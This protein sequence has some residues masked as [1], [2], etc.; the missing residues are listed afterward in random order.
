MLLPDFL[1]ADW[2]WAL[3]PVSC[4]ACPTEQ[5]PPSAPGGHAVAS[6]SG[7][8][9]HDGP[10]FTCPRLILIMATQAPCWNTRSLFCFVFYTAP[11]GP[12]SLGFLCRFFCLALN[13]LQVLFLRGPLFVPRYLP[14]VTSSIPRA[15]TTTNK[16]MTLKSHL[17][18]PLSWVTHTAVPSAHLPPDVQGTSNTTWK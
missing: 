13:S 4:P 11:F 14:R 9:T 7:H 15:S 2:Q 18:W 16:G 6:P 5:A 8:L 10:Y 1:G 12:V 17:H 3:F